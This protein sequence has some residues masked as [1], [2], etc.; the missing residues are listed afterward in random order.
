MAVIQDPQ[1]AYFELWEPRMHF[2]AAVVN[3]PG[4][5]V[6]RAVHAR[7]GRRGG[8]LRRPVR[9]DHAGIAG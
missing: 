4:A 8:V 5:P 1:G 6:E 7:S 2:G 3:E 9:M